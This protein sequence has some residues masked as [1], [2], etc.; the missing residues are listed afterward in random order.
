MTKTRPIAVTVL[1]VLA[2]IAALF[3][4]VHTLQY[5]HLF[6]F[7]LGDMAF[8]GFDLGAAIMWGLL[9]AIYV[10]LMVQLL[11][12]SPQAWL[13]LVV[14]SGLNLFLAVLSILGATTFQA[15]LPAILVSGAILLYCLM[16]STRAAFG[17][18]TN[19]P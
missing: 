2:G 7:F 4:A 6:P 13:Y 14:L 8:F 19:M 17:T 10:W 1:A 3:A 11:N 9:A 15:M 16:P 12:V 5:L 18:S